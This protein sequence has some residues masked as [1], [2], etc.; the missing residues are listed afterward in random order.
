[1]R[2]P[3]G[4]VFHQ[5]TEPLV[6]GPIRTAAKGGYLAERAS[7]NAWTFGI[8]PIR[9]PCGSAC[10][11]DQGGDALFSRMRARNRAATA[12][13]ILDSAG[14]RR[15]TPAS[16]MGDEAPVAGLPP[17]PHRTRNSA[18]PIYARRVAAIAFPLIA[19]AASLHTS[20]T[21]ATRHLRLHPIGWNTTWIGSPA[22]SRHPLPRS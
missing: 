11:A 5:G 15:T 2:S 8:R 14:S 20:H 16:R 22:W 18:A 9:V 19:T 1:L 17:I 4:S 7:S 10:A 21:P 3:G 13:E 6:I 12:D